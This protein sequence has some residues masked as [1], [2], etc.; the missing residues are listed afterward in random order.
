MKKLPTIEDVAK[1]AKV[2]IAT[3]S[4]VIN[5]KDKVSKKTTARIES[6]IEELDY[7]PSFIA[8]GLSIRKTFTIG[9]IMEDVVN[10]FFSQIVKGIGEVLQN[11]G[12]FMLLTNSE[13]NSNNE[14]KLTQLLIKQNVDG[15][16][17]AP[18]NNDSESLRILKENE[19]L[20]F[21]VNCRADINGF[22]YISTDNLLG[23]YIGT[24][25]LIEQG[26]EKIMYIRGTDDQ[27]SLDKLEGFK[28]AIIESGL[29]VKDQIIIGKAKTYDDGKRIIENFIKK[30]GI[31]SI[32]EAIFTANDHSALGVMRVLNDFN[33]RIP[34]DIS[35]L[36]YDDIDESGL[37]N[38][39]LS[40]I[41]QEKYKMGEI[42][43]NE[44]LM[45][46]RNKEENVAKQILIKPVLVIRNSVISKK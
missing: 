11:N 42:A 23:G 28:K 16:I 6:V 19:V 33:L 8:R 35:I 12:Y 26:Y 34:Q 41:R 38:I 7:Q 4:R 37:M 32:P 17:I 22:D 30:N 27:P 29:K 5:K 31:K 10:P 20:F 36:G 39:S 3:V 45:K 21:A 43:A 46:I 13:F 44:L 14:K 2:S 15:I 24:K 40:T 18:I 25:Y 9:V 1:K